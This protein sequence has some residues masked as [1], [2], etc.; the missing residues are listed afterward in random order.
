MVTQLRPLLILFKYFIKKSIKVI[1]GLNIRPSFRFYWSKVL[2]S[3]DFESSL[4]EENFTV[5]FMICPEVKNSY[6]LLVK[7][8]TINGH[9]Q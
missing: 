7:P 1:Q 6:L 9:R 3:R 2:P 5:G 8:Q 4:P